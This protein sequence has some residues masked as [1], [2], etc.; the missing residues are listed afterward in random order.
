MKK[1]LFCAKTLSAVIILSLV[2]NLFGITAFASKHSVGDLIQFGS[3]PQTLCDDED[4]ISQLDK[5]DKNWK[6]YDYYGGNGDY[7]S[8]QKGKYSYYADVSY[9]GKK[10][11]AVYIEEYRPSL[12]TISA[13][14]ASYQANM[15][16]LTDEDFYENDINMDNYVGHLF[17]SKLYKEKVY[18][19][20]YEPILWQVLDPSTGFVVSCDILDAQPFCNTLYWVD[21]NGDGSDYDDED[22]EYF[23]DKSGTSYANN[24]EHSSIRE[25]LNDDFYNTAFSNSEKLAIQYTNVDN[26]NILKQMAEHMSVYA[27]IPYREK[28][29]DNYACGYTT[30]EIFLLSADEIITEKYGFEAYSSSSVSQDSDTRTASEISDYAKSQGLEMSYGTAP[31][32]LRSPYAYG[33][34]MEVYTITSSGGLGR[35][36]THDTGHGIRPAMTVDLSSLTAY[37][38]GDGSYSDDG[39]GYI[40]S[41]DDYNS[42]DSYYEDNDGDDDIYSS[43][44]CTSTDADDEAGLIALGI[45]IVVVVIVLIIRSRKKKA[46]PKNNN[47]YPHPNQNNIQLYDNQYFNDLFNDL[48]NNKPK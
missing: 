6:Y 40:D 30:D 16:F 11:R 45:I 15:S 31:V 9:G 46:L 10:Y 29:A 34:S 44:N 35:T 20:E 18:Y 13:S 26:T 38:G 8:M 25:W 7:G 21:K 22:S 37:S 24:W 27:S 5:I 4:I 36:T 3:Y 17:D 33:N 2:L 39:S 19:F 47:I 41:D 28:L 14:T 1:A 32:L 42:D 23:G 48:N 43:T 12:T